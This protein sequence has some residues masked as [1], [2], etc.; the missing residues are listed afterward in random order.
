MTSITAHK[1]RLA[2]VLR[3]LLVAVIWIAIWQVAFFFV[4]QEILLPSPA[5][6]IVRLWELAQ[7]NNFW[8]SAFMSLLRIVEGFIL[9]VAAGAILGVLTARFSLLYDFFHPAI[10]IIKATPVA[11]FIILALVWIKKDNVPV[12]IAFLMVLPIIWANVSEGIHQTDKD[13]LEMAKIFRFTRKKLASKVYIPSTLPYFFAGCTTALG[14]AWKAG[15]AAE[16]LSLPSH[17]IG[18]ELY[19]SKIY[20]ETTDLFA[21]T[22]TV[23]IMSIILERLLV[24]ILNKVKDNQR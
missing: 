7:L 8:I 1:P 10:S 2:G 4:K 9:G 6:T 21:W 18:S 11:S 22:A 14:L 5:Q 15:I 12:F 17:S 16:I 24:L 23:I 19:N 3:K 20:I 13:L